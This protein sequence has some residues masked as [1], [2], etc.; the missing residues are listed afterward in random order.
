MKSNV[1]V[2]RKYVFFKNSNSIQFDYQPKENV[3]QIN[4]RFKN[5]S[6]HTCYYTCY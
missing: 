3:A 5:I 4:V 2:N 1:T 6:F